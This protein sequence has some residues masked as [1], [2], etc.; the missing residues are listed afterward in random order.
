MSPGDWNKNKMVA[1]APDHFPGGEAD[2]HGGT[3]WTNYSQNL[4]SLIVKNCV[5]KRT[6]D[7]N[8]SR[9]VGDEIGTDGTSNSQY[10]GWSSQAGNAYRRT[11]WLPTIEIKNNFVNTQ[12]KPQYKQNQDG[13]L[14]T[15]YNM[16]IVEGW[17]L[18]GNL[19]MNSINHIG[20]TMA[21]FTWSP[22]YA[23]NFI[24]VSNQNG[25]HEPAGIGSGDFGANQSVGY[26]HNGAGANVWN[27]SIWK[28]F[29]CF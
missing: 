29:R 15:D 2:G 4:A 13:S 27:S 17:S 12:N 1:F 25:V 20:E 11:F 14:S 19:S 3:G 8:I 7:Y 9:L 10:I 28:Y 22:T 18:A 16:K 24:L 5:M 23:N 6:Y 26:P 21:T